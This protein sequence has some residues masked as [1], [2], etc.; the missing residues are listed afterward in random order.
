MPDLLGE[1]RPL[2]AG[3]IAIFLLPATAAWGD[4]STGKAAYDQRSAARYADLFQSLDRN[5]DGVVMHSE[6]GGDLNF[7]QRF[8]DMDINRDGVVTMPELQRFIKQQH[9]VSIEPGRRP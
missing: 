8:D 4:S 7:G 6:I 1:L 9:G 3:L 5:R 2:H